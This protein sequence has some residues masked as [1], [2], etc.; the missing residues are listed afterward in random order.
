MQIMRFVYCF[1]VEIWPGAYFTLTWV[2]FN[3]S[4]DK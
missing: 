3:P 4:I 2:N 1:G